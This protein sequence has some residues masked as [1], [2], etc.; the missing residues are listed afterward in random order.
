MKIEKITVI[1][2]IIFMLVI[3][4]GERYPS[5]LSFIL[6]A[7][8]PDGFDFSENRHVR[9]RMSLFFTGTVIFWAL[10]PNIW[11]YGFYGGDTQEVKR[12]NI[13]YLLYGILISPIIW[14]GYPFVAMCSDCWA[15]NDFF[16]F[17]LTV[18]IFLALH[19]SVQFI[20]L[21]IALFLRNLNDYR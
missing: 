20:L 16:Y 12:L 15:K 3:F 21:K 19:I 8:T 13:W 9:F 17:F 7:F 18:G 11:R 2:I 6:D 5:Q 1:Y 14:M 4:L 10:I